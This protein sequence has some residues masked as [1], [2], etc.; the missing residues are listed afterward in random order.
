MSLLSLQHLV[1]LTDETGLIQHAYYGIP[2]RRDGYSADDNARAL[3]LVARQYAVEPREQLVD[4][5]TIYLS[6]LQH[7]QMDNG[8]F[9][10][11]LDYDQH[12][13]DLPTGDD[14]QGRCL[15]AL[16]ELL[17]STMPASLKSAAAEMLDRALGWFRPERPLHS[18][19]FA[20]LGFDALSRRGDG[21]RWHDRMAPAADRLAGALDG[22]S[23]NGWTWFDDTMTYANGRLPHA[24]LAAA[25]MLG[26]DRYLEAGRKS[27][28]FLIRVTVQDDML[29][30]VGTDGWYPQGGVK[31]RFDQQPIEA[32]ALIEAALAAWTIL[33]ETRY[34][35]VARTC[36]RWF[37]GHNCLGKPLADIEEG[38]CCDGLTPYGPNANQ[39]AE[40]TLSLLIS[41]QALAKYDLND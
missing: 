13:A 16:A 10:N 21:D 33:N 30:P 38:S 11:F 15:W 2:R 23:A 19:A 31:A 22:A 37:V 8:M 5:A 17:A 25:R 29:V 14:C 6:Y 40:S 35:D 1:R 9:R 41:R 12:W 24:M 4:L 28:D 7:G 27:L 20:L 34:L 36:G 3:I 18:L 26:R 39:G 32:M